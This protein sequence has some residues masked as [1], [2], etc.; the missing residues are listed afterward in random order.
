MHEE[1]RDKMDIPVIVTV[2]LVTVIL[3]VL[4]VV[5]TEAY[6]RFEQEK[7]NWVRVIE[8]PN[9]DLDQLN[10][11]ELTQIQQYRWVD[12]E[13]KLVAIPIEDAMKAYAQQAGNQK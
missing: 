3:V 9:D 8:A 2:A 11:Q 13:K 5:T 12:R 4:S 7:I 6:F 1:P 10:T